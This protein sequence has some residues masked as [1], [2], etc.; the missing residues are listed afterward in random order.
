MRPWCRYVFILGLCV[1]CLSASGAEEERPWIGIANAS[2]FPQKLLNY[3]DA[4]GWSELRMSVFRDAK[5]AYERRHPV[6]ERLLYTFLWIDLMYEPESDY[7]NEWVEKMGKANRLHSNM[8][9]QIPFYEGVLGE[10]LS[11]DFLKYFFSRGDLMR[12]TYNQWD[13]SDLLTEFFTILDR[14]FS[15][16]QYLFKQ[17]PELAFAIA[18]VH[19]VPPTPMWPHP[20]VSQTV[21]PRQLRSADEVF[22]YFTNPRDAKWFHNSIKR[23]SL[24][25]AIF[26]VDLVVS[27]EEIQW[28][29]SNVTV[30][31]L[32]YD[33]VYTMI[34]YDME[35]LQRGQMYWIYNDYSLPA[36][37]KVGGIC[38]DQAYFASQVGKTQGLP[39]I[40]FLGSGLDGRHAW[41]GYLN[42]RGKWEM[43]A[44]RYADQRFVTGHAFNPQTWSFISDHEVEFLGA[45]YHKARSF[46]RSQVHFYWARILGFMD[47][48]DEAVNAAEDAVAL[49]R[50]NA[51]AWELLIDLRKRNQTPRNRVDATYRSA[52][53][54]LRIYSDLEAKFRA[55]FADYLD[56]TG[57]DNAARV[58]RNRITFRNKDGRSDLA[59][60]NAVT[61][62]EES[63]D[64]D[65]RTAQ[66]YVYKKLVN[67]LGGQAGIQLLD[68]LAV[69]FIN[70][71]L[72][73]GR[74]GD[75]K[76]AIL[77]AERVL[78]PS[79]GSQLKKEI[80]RVKSQLG[81]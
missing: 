33:G 38:V 53:S 39:T 3:R 49:E 10:R 55:A 58:E 44:G 36:I 43:D 12:S 51:K 24:S 70:Y 2:V 79:D 1:F 11:D 16:H 18:Y 50:R 34:R 26:M 59:I 66:M 13:P 21:L 40:E 7:V 37:H 15:K 77:E 5:Y 71:L 47:Q 9:A 25:D 81:L 67:E 6:A 68:E 69:P 4:H 60:K 78:D 63:M 20:Q 65:M 62:L 23:L 35:R 64:S 19:D 74:S 52:L 14:L 48:L 73:E 30:S 72:K 31:P 75:A 29:R 57:R 80:S 27:P 61:V 17:Y 41:F 8:P 56:A 46:Y 28:V 42:A 22:E 45:G 32:E 54:A 76:T